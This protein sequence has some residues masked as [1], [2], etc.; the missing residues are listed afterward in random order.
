MA[1]ELLDL[2]E[3][4]AAAAT[5]RSR[6]ILEDEP[7]PWRRVV[8]RRGLGVSLRL[9][10]QI[11][12][13][14]QELEEAIR[15]GQESGL[16]E[17]TE[18]ARASLAGTLFMA[19]ETDEALRALKTAIGRLDG[20]PRAEAR[21]QLGTIRARMGDETATLAE[22]RAALPVLARHGLHRV[23]AHL[24][25]NR[26]L[27]A[28][29]RGHVRDAAADFELAEAWYRR[30]GVLGPAGLMLQ[31]QA[32][33][34]ATMGSF[35]RALDL[36][37][38]AVET[39]QKAGRPTQ[40]ALL[41]RAEM[42]LGL[43]LSHEALSTA[44]QA[45]QLLDE[46]GDRSALA[47]GELVLCRV[48][49]DAGDLEQAERSAAHAADLFHQH[50]RERWALVSNYLSYESVAAERGLTAGQAAECEHLADQLEAEGLWA[51]SRAALAVA[52]ESHSLSER[53]L[54]ARR[55]HAR[56]SEEV[57]LALTIREATVAALIDLQIGDLPACLHHV[58]RGLSAAGQH[59]LAISATE[60]RAANARQVDRLVALGIEL[61]ADDPLQQSLFVESN[62]RASL[63]IIDPI[64]EDQTLAAALADYRAIYDTRAAAIRE[65][66]AIER[67]LDVRQ[68]SLARTGR[69]APVP[70]PFAAA[71]IDA[72]DDGDVVLQHFVDRGTLF[73]SVLAREHHQR[74]RI[75][76]LPAVL[77]LASRCSFGLRFLAEGRT[78]LTV[79]SL[80]DLNADLHELASLLVPDIAR[81]AQRLVLSLPSWLL[82]VSSSSIQQRCGVPT[83]IAT[84]L[85]QWCRRR[86][87]PTTPRRA[88]L[89]EGPRLRVSDNEIRRL[90]TIYEVADVLDGDT[91]THDA[92]VGQM[93]SCDVVHFACHGEF[94][95]ENPM[96][97]NL[98][99]A[100]GPLMGY[101]FERLAA[102]PGTVV[103]A[104][105]D[106]GQSS[107][108]P[109]DEALGLVQPMLAA[110]THC[111][112]AAVAPV[113]DSD[114]THRLMERLHTEL[115]RGV[116]PAQAL[117]TAHASDDPTLEERLVSD[118]YTCLV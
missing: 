117:F 85:T 61:L 56:L 26:G 62:R 34:E 2:A 58:Q 28:L 36:G 38:R 118:L 4:D 107:A 67:R 10:G 105:C 82:R 92:V 73:C 48:A 57:P 17:E 46:S 49:I 103:L 20:V 22:Y 66:L 27:V 93:Q 80:D 76:R 12:R 74:V 111:V 104:A 75:A 101:D 39:L 86:G 112:I 15:E 40:V 99:L 81:S 11:E 18:L 84:S 116:E 83:L 45:V 24:L 50:G 90:A 106:V 33:A 55:A 100:D 91:A 44:R 51:Y 110:G 47:E 23:A 6:R 94:Q 97:S 37:N 59:R 87:V 98:L 21:F 8:A 88:T 5:A 52:A 19:G 60:A 65:P 53:W 72:L 70:T 29:E 35:V 68:A 30:V 14:R 95:A 31:N 9:G 114:T 77:D 63:R 108:L 115:S 1:R 64:V 7:E 41:D 69:L 32:L 25:G 16:T 89:V 78:P 54:D 42:L 113:P 13:S 3:D 109:G 79:A 43:G 96:F 71:D 102:M